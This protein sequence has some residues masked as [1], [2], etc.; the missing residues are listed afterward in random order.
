MKPWER[1]SFN[2][3]NVIVALTGIVYFYMKYLIVT[4]DPFTVINHA[5]EPSMLSLHVVTSPILLIFFGMVFRSHTLKK[6]LSNQKPDRRTG[7][8]SLISFSSMALTGYFLQILSS[9]IWL[10]WMVV[11][12]VATSVIFL[13]GYSAHLVLGWRFIK[14]SQKLPVQVSSNS[15]T[16]QQPL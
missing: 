7:W 16:V 9:P 5:W 10:Q 13:I 15:V 2:T 11:L 4:D 1:R 6:I 8:T 12:H 3:L 14:A